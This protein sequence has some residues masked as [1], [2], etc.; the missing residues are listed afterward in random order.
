MIILNH[1]VN[2]ADNGDKGDETKANCHQTQVESEAKD[3]ANDSCHRQNRSHYHT[4][5]II[6]NI[7]LLWLRDKQNVYLYILNL[8]IYEIREYSNFII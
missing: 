8:F 4:P 6:H 3:Y 5:D 1:R 7:F 2:D